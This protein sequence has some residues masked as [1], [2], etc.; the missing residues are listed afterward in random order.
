MTRGGRDVA[1]R[2]TLAHAQQGLSIVMHLESPARH[3]R[4]SG[5]KLKG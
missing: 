1:A 3:L 2:I 5:Q 4:P